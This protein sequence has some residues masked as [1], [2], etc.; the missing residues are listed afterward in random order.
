MPTM[1]VHNIYVEVEIA[2]V[3]SGHRNDITKM[4]RMVILGIRSMLQQS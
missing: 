1:C 3:T 4:E 2:L